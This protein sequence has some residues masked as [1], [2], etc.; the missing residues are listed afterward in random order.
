ML[1]RR[2]INIAHY[3]TNPVRGRKKPRTFVHFDGLLPPSRSPT[4]TGRWPLP[5][6]RPFGGEEERGS[7]AA[8]Q[9]QGIAGGQAPWPRRKG[10]SEEGNAPWRIA[11]PD[12]AP[13]VLDRRWKRVFQPRPGRAKAPKLEPR[14]REGERERGSPASWM[15]GWTDGTGRAAALG[16]RQPGG[17]GQSGGRTARS[18]AHLLVRRPR[19]DGRTGGS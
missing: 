19:T 10:V 5:A 16:A 15:D 12:V 7:Q 11:V 3:L 18:L 9:S 6:P 8:S 14:G 2:P 1:L 17:R 13:I 4:A